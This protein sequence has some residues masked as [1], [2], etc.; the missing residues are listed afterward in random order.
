MEL[1]RIR[2]ILKYCK[3]NEK[4]LI[5]VVKGARNP[6]E[7][8]MTVSGL[9]KNIQKIFG[10]KNMQKIIKRLAAGTL[11]LAMAFAIVASPGTVRAQDTSIQALLDLRNLKWV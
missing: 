8:I 1:A 6:T 2:P 10:C 5:D 9:P 4:R 7:R 3:R 11:G